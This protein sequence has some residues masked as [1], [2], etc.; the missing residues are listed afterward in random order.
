MKPGNYNL[1]HKLGRCRFGLLL[2]IIIFY[3]LAVH[4][5]SLR[6]AVIGDFGGGTSNETAV[7]NQVKSWNPSFV[8]TVGDN[9]YGSINFDQAVGKDYC[10]FLK[11]AGSGTNCGGNVASI[12]SFF[13]ALGN[14]DYTDGGGLS[15]YLSYFSLPG[16]GVQSSNTSG[17][18]RYYDVIQG[19]VHLFI[20][21]SQGATTN[22]TDMTAQK[23]WLQAQL[24]ASTAV[25][26]IVVDHHAP[27]SSCSTHGSVAAMQWP[28]QS[29]G[30][31]AMF[32]GHDHTYERVVQNGFP[33]FVDGYSGYTLYNFGTP[34]TGSQV[35][36]SSTYGAIRVDADIH[37]ITF[38][39]INK[40]GVTVD[41]YSLT[42][43]N[44][45]VFS[46]DIITKA[47]VEIGTAYT[48][49][50]STE[51]ADP[52]GDVVTYSK[53]AGPAWLTVAS[54]G[55]LS[56]TPA[57]S[58]IG[59]NTFI[60]SVSDGYGGTDQAE[61]RI[62]VNDKPHLSIGGYKVFYG[63]LHNHSTISDGTGT[64][65]QAYA[66]ARD[67]GKLDFFSLADHSNNSG[68]IDAADWTAMKSAA[69]TYNQDGIFT[70]FWGFEW[71]ESVL[72]HVAIINSTD[73]ITTA[74][75]QNTFA[76]LCS[77]LNNNECVA[78][79]NHPG[80]Q[81]STG[82][83]FEHFT[84]T[85]TDKIV[86]MELWNKTDRFNVYYYT[87]GYFSGDGNLS[88]YDE[89]LTRGWKI[90]AAGSEDNHSGTWGTM[91]PSKLAILSAALTR[92]EL[93]SA[94][95][96][97][98]FYS[99]Y[100]K[101]LALSFK[102]NGNEMGSTLT[103]GV[104]TF[105]I[106]ASDGE[107]EIFSQVEL[108]KKGVVVQTWTPNSASPNLTGNLTC[109][110]GDYFYVRVKQADNDE[111]I[112]SPIWISGGNFYPSCSITSPSGGTS[113]P[114]PATITIAASAS[115]IDGTIT[116]VEF[117]QGSTLL[118]S[119][120]SAPF[121]FTWN[122]VPAG[123][124]S[125]T[126]KATDD[127]GAVTTSDIINVTVTGG[128]L[129][130]VVSI[131]SPASG[132]S[133]SEPGFIM[134]NAAASDPDGS[135]AKV[136]FYV[137][138]ALMSED[139]SSPYE[140][141]WFGVPA[142]NY[143]LT[144]VATDDDGTVT[145]SPVVNVTVVHVNILPSVSIISPANGAS[146]TEPA[147][148]TINATAM[149]DVSVA[150]VEFFNGGTKLGED[151]TSPYSYTWNNV[152]AGNYSLT[153]K[154]TDNESGTSNSNVVNISVI[155]AGSTV[156]SKRITSGSDDVEE[157]ASGTVNR[158]SSVI[159]LVYYGPSTGNQVIGL[160]YTNVTIPAGAT[161]SNAYIQFG[162]SKKN[163]QSC[164]LT[165]KG[166]YTG[167]S[168]AF[169]TTLQN[170][171]NR[172]KTS[173]AVAWTPPSWTKSGEVGSAQKTPD[174]K[175][176]VQEILGHSAWA[177]GNSMTFII[178][179][180]GTRDAYAYEG[181]AIKAAQ[182]VVEYTLPAGLKAGKLSEVSDYVK[183][184]ES[185]EKLICYPVPFRNVL[186]I[187]FVPGEGERMESLEIYSSSGVLMKSFSVQ[188]NFLQIPL[189]NFAPGLYIIRGRSNRSFY[190]ETVIK[191]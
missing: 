24:A 21:D 30:A 6:F 32:S 153:A 102:I 104:Y 106:T 171:S 63:S 77:W 149:D 131:T 3:S 172:T 36:Y 191:N 128:N 80:R 33:Y 177:S 4:S 152:P 186:N 78:F 188:D 8:V 120:N 56:G 103:A 164:S 17:N 189:N 100:D 52:D 121:S 140:Y 154:V 85:P 127:D 170:V 156:F 22:S 168:A 95:K 124:Y 114:A 35:R 146:Y 155:S 28:Y 167:N 119:D 126:V 84:T 5:Q 101:T 65:A 169:T 94:L 129:P 90:G 97:R 44:P 14:H 182:L 11:D 43:N 96:A 82:H 190:K 49:T 115:D 162:A 91:T 184:V 10:P 89:A 39:A 116:N 86:G 111:A 72:G 181:S 147:T 105:Q 179:G 57:F 13:P 143:S 25:W 132:A 133:F 166:E 26:K 23:N 145:T 180:S 136:E 27:Y 165:I 112:S 83:E 69:N 144:A 18:E 1:I 157:Y 151:S 19:P 20:L 50:I 75:P 137:G 99:T 88:W 29:W 139:T 58:D 46:N 54:D 134:I 79:F 122:N 59:L 113:Y 98:R 173:A 31:D 87:D 15:Q 67:N 70:A 64:P 47:S 48:G 74:A 53:T 42:S 117:Y 160:R 40:D 61:L 93:M 141:Y 148:V 38:T 118:G 183:P 142:G 7:A 71:T 159:E 34:V 110:D 76:G 163:T 109:I 51:A 12:N 107:S 2:S 187:Q 175:T 60:V 130:P 9:R 174:M 45:P 185:A 178:T 108:L 16:I 81:N 68:S 62:T 138:S 55:T 135:V 123:D 125:L 73:Y 176:I 66:Y 161:I 92:T 150:L 41:T 37:T 158:T